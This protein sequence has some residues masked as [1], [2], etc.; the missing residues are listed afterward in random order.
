MANPPTAGSR[1]SCQFYKDFFAVNRAVKHKL[2]NPKR[3]E[4]SHGL[5]VVCRFS[6][7][8]PLPQ[9]L[10]NRC[11]SNRPPIEIPC[12]RCSFCEDLAQHRNCSGNGICQNNACVC[13][14]GWTGSVCDQTASTCLTGV[15]DATK[16]CCTSG[17]VGGGRCCKSAGAKLDRNGNCCES[18]MVDVCGQCDGKGRVIDV[19][20]KCCSVR[21][22]LM[23]KILVTEPCQEWQ[24]LRINAVSPH[25]QRQWHLHCW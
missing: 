21:S 3:R 11:P 17:L 25:L 19:A 2:D 23:P 20:G 13:T 24:T 5:Q 4:E 12:P 1:L 9:D 18:G 16:Q 15:V 6:N 7:G 8:E 22:T 14:P 10:W